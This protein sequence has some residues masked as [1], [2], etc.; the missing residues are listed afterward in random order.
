MVSPLPPFNDKKERHDLFSVREALLVRTLRKTRR[1][2]RMTYTQTTPHSENTNYLSTG[3][4][5]TWLDTVVTKFLR[6]ICI[7]IYIV[8]VFRGVAV[9]I[10]CAHY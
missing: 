1:Q 2:R 10:A 4:G 6:Q 8:D 5:L 9:V 7:N 3:I